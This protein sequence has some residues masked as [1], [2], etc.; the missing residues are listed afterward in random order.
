[1]DEL[2]V[3][4]PRLMVPRQVPTG[5]VSVD[6][7]HFL[8]HGLKVC[9]VFNKYRPTDLLGN[10]LTYN[11]FGANMYFGGGAAGPGLIT[12]DAAGIYVSV[13][14]TTTYDKGFSLVVH[15][16]APV[17][18]TQAGWI[19]FGGSNNSH[20]TY[21]NSIYNSVGANGVPINISSE[22]EFDFEQEIVVAM[23]TVKSGGYDNQQRAYFNGK[24]LASLSN[25]YD[26][27][28]PAT[29]LYMCGEPSYNGFKGIT[30][31]VFAYDR[32]ISPSEA[33]MLS[34]DPYQ[35]LIPA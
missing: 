6:K 32:V 11:S 26:M 34:T 16:Q 19:R 24:L 4:E 12:S 8:A 27:S 9:V 30:Y 33:S 21:N 25:V 5:S 35:F 17:R 22:S 7:S 28:S 10:L 18:S 13:P 23:T 29:V 3:R 2:W 1:M 31:S 14:F 15:Q 20:W